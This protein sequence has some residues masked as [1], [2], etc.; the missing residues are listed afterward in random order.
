[1]PG[2]NT[3]GV[4]DTNDYLLGRGIVYASVLVNGLPTSWRDLGNC[5]DF[6]LNV[7]KETLEHQSSRSGLKITDKEVVLSQ[8]AGYS[9]QLDEINNEN[10]ALFF[11]GNKATHTNPAVA[12]VAD[13]VLTS[14]AELGFWYDLVDGTGERLYDVTAGNLTVEADPSGTP[15]TLVLDTDYE[16]DAEMGRIRLKADAVNIADGDELGFDYTADA[17]ATAA[18]DQVNALT[19]TSVTIA[20]KFIGENPADNGSRYEVQIQKTAI[21]AEG[22]FA[23]ISDDWTTMTFTGSAERNDAYSEASGERFLRIRTVEQA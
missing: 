16:L 19:Q 22:D 11:S 8:S 7:E 14:S 10:M 13:I 12:G 18:V 6:S 15:V 20:L 17:G 5:P 21:L 1:M 2:P 4:P 23:L 3:S 9:F